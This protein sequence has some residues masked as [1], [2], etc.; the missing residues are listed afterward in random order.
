[1]K[2]FTLIELL[3]VFALISILL[4]NGFFALDV[5]WQVGFGWA[6]FLGRVL[7]RMSLDVTGTLI[8]LG[9][10]AG[11]AVGLHLFLGWLYAQAKGAGGP[12]WRPRWT[13]MI[14]GLVVLMFA[15]GLSV[16]GVAH[17]A[18]WMANSRV[19]MT[20]TSGG[21][22][23][24]AART[25][26]ANNLRQIG[27]AT[28]NYY[29]TRRGKLL[30]G[31]TFDARGTALHGWQTSLL[32]YLEQEELYRRIDREVPWNDPRNVD[33]FRTPVR[34]YLHS[35]PGE[36]DEA[37]FALTHYAANVRVL[38]GE[39]PRNIATIT[40]GLANTIL[41]GEVWAEYSPWGRPANW[42]DPARG[43]RSTPD[44]FGS[45]QQPDSA[46]FVF[47]DGSVKTL[48]KGIDPAVLKA[49]STPDGGEAIDP[50]DLI[51]ARKPQ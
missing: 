11:L 7:P 17:Q 4:A 6:L 24:I 15:A 33:A 14:V 10:L 37:G 1:V 39:K 2:R 43:I 44:S 3:V 30:L 19:P 40:D 16:V 26:S 46:Q 13:G 21:I 32:P 12:R 25:H 28:Y 36:R 5:L 35:V 29:N 9:C 42:R 48:K 18:A 38:G 20:Q 23:Q 49:L 47:M 34:V 31:A 22:R 50:A 27:L 41:A 51:P 8:A 45:P